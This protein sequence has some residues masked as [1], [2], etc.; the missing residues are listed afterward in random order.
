[1]SHLRTVSKETVRLSCS[2]PCD[3]CG[4]RL[5]PGMETLQ[6]VRVGQRTAVY[7]YYGP[8]CVIMDDLISNEEVTSEP[9][10]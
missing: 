5:L 10:A 9:N 1:M 2:M 8:C 4:V 7:D 3:G 6:I